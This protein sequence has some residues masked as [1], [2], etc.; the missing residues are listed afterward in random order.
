[1][2]NNEGVSVDYYQPRK[3]TATKTLITAKDHAAV[4]LTVGLVDENG[5]YTNEVETV[6]LCGDLRMKSRSDAA[7]NRIM[8][9]QKIMKDVQ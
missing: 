7:L 9:E 1:M 3:C 4:Q 8:L 6:T 5:V 2:Q